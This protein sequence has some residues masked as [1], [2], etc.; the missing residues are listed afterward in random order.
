MPVQDVRKTRRRKTRTRRKATRGQTL[1]YL[2]KEDTTSA[3]SS[4]LS[5]SLTEKEEQDFSLAL[6]RMEKAIQ[7]NPN[8]AQ[9]EGSDWAWARTV[10]LV[11]HS[12]AVTKDKKSDMR[13][14]FREEIGKTNPLASSEELK[15]LRAQAT[16]RSALEWRRNGRQSKK[17]S[18]LSSSPAEK[19]IEEELLVRGPAQDAF[20]AE[21][22]L[23]LTKQ[24]NSNLYQEVKEANPNAAA[25]ELGS[26]LRALK[27][28]AALVWHRKKLHER[29]DSSLPFAG[30]AKPT[31]PLSLEAQP[32]TDASTTVRYYLSLTKE[33]RTP[34]FEATKLANPD[35]DAKEFNKAYKIALWKADSLK[36]GIN[37]EQNWE[38]VDFSPVSDTFS[39]DSD[40][41]SSTSSED[42]MQVIRKD[43]LKQRQAPSA[44][45][46]LENEY[47]AGF[48]RSP[49]K[50]QPDNQAKQ[51]LDKDPFSLISSFKQVGIITSTEE[52]VQRAGDSTG[53]GGSMS[54]HHGTPS[55]DLPAD[56]HLDSMQLAVDLI[57]AG[58]SSSSCLEKM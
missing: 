49:D 4:T 50:P 46:S 5:L 43:L 11:Q 55:L 3:D 26:A 32:K 56:A 18:L 39:E 2:L 31:E 25:K 30:T 27:V 7:E 42:G 53:H 12:R 29:K 8:A 13:R 48:M 22:N 41:E 28:Q 17:Y 38:A 58:S 45:S 21:F 9:E 44:S 6:D 23:S 10:L 34:V 35:A 15:S 19:K 1:P 37:P 16:L 54:A 20:L 24:D 36:K 51:T 14:K 57:R 47:L 52:Q 33:E 40:Q